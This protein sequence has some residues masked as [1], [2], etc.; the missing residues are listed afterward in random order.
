MPTLSAIQVQLKLR[1]ANVVVIQKFP[2]NE[3]SK[4]I[5]KMTGESLQMQRLNTYVT[6]YHN[7]PL[8]NL[9]LLSLDGRPN[10]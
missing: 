3:L 4:M 1:A 8:L 2:K 5:L 9:R 6:R 7:E 10:Y